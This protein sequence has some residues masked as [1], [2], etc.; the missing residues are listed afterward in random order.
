VSDLSGRSLRVALSGF[1]HDDDP[2]IIADMQAEID[3]LRAENERLRERLE[4][5]H[6]WQSVGGGPLE[7]VPAPEGIP[8]GIECR[9]ETIKLQ[10]ARI[11]ELEGERDALIH[12]NGNLL[13][14]LSGE[15][16]ARV[17]AEGERDTATRA[18]RYFM[19]DPRFQ[20]G[21]GGNPIA[22]D[23]MLAEVRAIL[24]ALSKTEGKG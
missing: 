17:S 19:E 12:D 13:A 18:L 6:V 4:I 5:T 2:T 20:V 10:D 1:V 9:D 16:A 14:S 8:D 23:R 21:V 11:T 15:S 7:R 3:R 22:V 24:A